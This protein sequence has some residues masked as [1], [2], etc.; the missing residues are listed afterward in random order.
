MGAIPR[1]RQEDAVSSEERS[2]KSVW[3][4]KTREE[5][6]IKSEPFGLTCEGV[7]LLKSLISMILTKANRSCSSLR[8]LTLETIGVACA[9]E[10]Y[11]I[12]ES[13]GA[14]NIA[15]SEVPPRTIM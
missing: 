12:N 6:T 13:G 8:S 1:S 7:Y 5:K 4:D 9:L 2:S 3:E 14:M 15:R 10:L 11:T